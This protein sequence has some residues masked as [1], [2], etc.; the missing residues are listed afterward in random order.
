MDGKKF[1]AVARR[2]ARGLT[3]RDALRGLIVGSAA[4]AAGGGAVPVAA[5][6]QRCKR[7]GAPCTST[8][9]C[10]PKET[11][12]LCK[13][14]RNAGNSDET[15]CGGVGATCGGKNGVGDDRAPFCCVNH[16]CRGRTCRKA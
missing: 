13:V 4:A 9:Q 12:R 1:D 15:C 5:A 16:E 11:N 10:C 14:Q 3:R 7:A 2:L 8:K 6:E